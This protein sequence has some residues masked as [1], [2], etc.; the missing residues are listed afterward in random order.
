MY[1]NTAPTRQMTV[2]SCVQ[3][4][5]QDIRRVFRRGG[6]TLRGA[7]RLVLRRARGS[8]RAGTAHAACH[9]RTSGGRR[10]GRHAGPLRPVWRGTVWTGKV[11]RHRRKHLIF[12]LIP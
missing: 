2:M 5:S 11:S 9:E 8:A 3:V 1:L 10:A 7:L 12:I 6:A 4:P